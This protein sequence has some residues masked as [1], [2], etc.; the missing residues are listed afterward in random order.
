MILP[1]PEGEGRGEGEWALESVDRGSLAIGS[2]S[3]KKLPSHWVPIDILVVNVAR[4]RLA[5]GDEPLRAIRSHP[6][7]I[8]GLHRMPVVVQTIDPLPF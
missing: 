8:A 7:Y 5:H 2:R 3:P 4:R 1:L 6:D